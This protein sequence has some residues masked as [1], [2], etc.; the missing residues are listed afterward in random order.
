MPSGEFEL[1][2]NFF[3]SHFSS[4]HNQVD[5]TL[6]IDNGD[7]AAA[8]L[9]E[10]DHA[11][12]T[13]VDTLVAGV[14]FPEDA[15]VES[16]GFKSLAVNVSDIAAMGGVPKWATLALTIP[17]Y[18]KSWLEAF[19]KGFFKIANQY[20][21]KL[22]GGDTTKGPL[23]VS[24]QLMGIVEQD[25][26]LLRGGAK[27]GD[28][29]FVTGRLG[30]AGIGLDSWQKKTDLSEIAQCYHDRLNYPEPQLEIGRKIRELASAAIDI[31]DGLAS[32]LIH[33]LDASKVGAK[34]YEDNIPLPR[35]P[36][37]LLPR[38]L[39][40]YAL[41]SGDDYQLCFT[42]SPEYAENVLSIS[43]EITEIGEVISGSK[44]ILESKSG[45][46]NIVTADGYN[47]FAS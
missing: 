6:L 16:I 27:V 17:E 46:E 13:C 24:V 12:L 43:N 14:H 35:L 18:D 42:A 21:I 1:I 47:H 4:S 10:P 3:S 5:E 34:I 9:V 15:P 45:A 36:N 25:K 31:S 37:I 8:V 29:I 28:K 38:T 40:Q 30:E 33:I 44:L 7:D 41:Y 23:T 32:D 19:S 20:G 22:I 39:L 26:Q 11:L 2:N